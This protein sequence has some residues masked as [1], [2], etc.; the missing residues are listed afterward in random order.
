MPLRTKGGGS[1]FTSLPRP[2]VSTD[3]RGVARAASLARPG[4]SFRAGEALCDFA[5]R[6]HIQPAQGRLLSRRRSIARVAPE[7][8][9]DVA[10]Y[11][12]RLGHGRHH[13]LLI[14]LFS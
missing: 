7:T 6:A 8:L 3:P 1:R 12:A 11:G 5:R 10:S 4:G 9:N 13:D 14:T 2:T